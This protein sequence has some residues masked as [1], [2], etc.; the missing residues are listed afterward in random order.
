MLFK[1][2]QSDNNM[3]KSLAIISIVYLLSQ[4]FILL[5]TG[6]WWDEK[7]WFFAT[8]EQMWNVSMQLGKPSSFF[9][10]A[11][12]TAIPEF[13]GR[14]L[15][16][17]LFYFSAIIMFALYSKIPFIDASDALLMTILYII[18]PVNDARALLGVFPYSLGF[19]LFLL[20]FYLLT[21]LQEEYQ[22]KR[23]FFRGLVILV[24]TGSFTLNSNLVLYFIPLCYIFIY[25]VKTKDVRGWYKYI[26]FLIIP[27]MYFGIK[28]RFFPP[29]GLYEGYNSVGIAE[30]CKATLLSVVE[31]LDALKGIMCLWWRYILIGLVAGIVLYKFIYTYIDVKDKS[32][33]NKCIL[34]AMGGV[35]FYLGVFPYTVIGQGQNLIGVGGRSSVLLGIGMAM[36]IYAVLLWIPQKQIRVYICSVLVICGII[37]FNYFYLLYQQDY[38]IQLDFMQELKEN[39]ECL[40]D[41]KNLLYLTDYNSEI[42]AT[43]FYTLNSNA[44]QVFEDQ[45]RFIMNGTRDMNYLT[46][47]KRLYEFVNK[48]DYQMKDYEI[49]RSD[50]IEAVLYYKNSISLGDTIRLKMLEITNYNEF[51]DHLYE[52]RNLEISIEI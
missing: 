45:S 40:E 24:F 41:K 29:Y 8:N 18:I 15:I 16:F 27:F 13:C 33:I 52:T 21:K 22:Y 26:D 17:I 7:T 43:R 46:D 2:I 4:G 20:G 5:L 37:H 19:F 28:N 35:A 11:I 12:I 51:E 36:I 23:S 42:G 50:G 47:E 38:Y 44:A 14:V 30:I 39:F 32:C 31:C 6:T 34:L 49:G 1:E 3:R 48:G 25:L 9:V 10:F